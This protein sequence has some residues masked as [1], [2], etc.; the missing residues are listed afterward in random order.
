MKSFMKTIITCLLCF[1]CIWQV[2]TIQ[3]ATATLPEINWLA[4]I[5]QNDTVNGGLAP[6][7]KSI[8]YRYEVEKDSDVMLDLTVTSY[9][10]G[11]SVQMYDNSNNKI[12][13]ETISKTQNSMSGTMK[14]TMCLSSGVYYIF[15]IA[16]GETGNYTITTETQKLYNQDIITDSSKKND[17]MK[18]AIVVPVNTVYTGALN[19]R[20]TVD[21]YR[22]D[23]NQSG[24]LKC[25]FDYYFS[26]CN[27]RI[28]DKDGVQLFRDTLKWNEALKAGTYLYQTALQKGTYYFE[29]SRNQS[30]NTVQNTGKYYFN[31]KFEGVDI[32][33][34][35]PNDDLVTA[36]TLGIG[37]K[38]K[39]LITLGGDVD[40]YKI[41]V[42]KKRFLTFVINSDIQN[43]QWTLYNRKYEQIKTLTFTLQQDQTK[44]NMSYTCEMPVGTYYFQV[45]SANS[46]GV[47]DVAVNNTVAPKKTTITKH[48]TTRN[49]STS[50]NVQIWWKS[51]SGIDGYEVYISNSSSF[52]GA[53]PQNVTDRTTTFSIEKGKRYYVRIRSYKKTGDGKM[54]YSA[55]STKKSYLMKK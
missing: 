21:L 44:N 7:F 25:Q 13:A 3:A 36:E 32:N 26:D 6:N 40:T 46:T 8:A 52:K 34:V 2:N 38:K 29:V 47:Y 23:L 30:S 19:I 16:S 45:K 5:K 4:Y 35:E 51:I 15:V 48:K 10:N 42:E 18:N 1:C 49:S 28:L 27:V 39:A 17:T 11:V 55:F 22:V 9:M 14:K 43:Y 24:V 20:E 12:F 50:S 54:L 33:E 37:A 31:L 41:Q 53:T